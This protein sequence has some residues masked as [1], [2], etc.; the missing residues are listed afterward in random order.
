MIMEPVVKTVMQICARTVPNPVKIAVLHVVQ[1]ALHHLGPAT[2]KIAQSVEKVNVN[3][4]EKLR[5]KNKDEDQVTNN[6]LVHAC[7]M[8]TPPPPTTVL[9]VCISSLQPA[10]NVLKEIESPFITPLSSSMD[11]SLY[12]SPIL[13]SGEAVPTDSSIIGIQHLPR[14]ILFEILYRSSFLPLPFAIKAFR[15]KDGQGNVYI[16]KWNQLRP[17][18]KEKP[19]DAWVGCMLNPNVNASD[20]LGVMDDE[21]GDQNEPDTGT[22]VSD[23]SSDDEA[24]DGNEDMVHDGLAPDDH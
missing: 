1:I 21:A 20:M 23:I 5:R 8:T 11:S 6:R 22:V 15:N 16:I 9:S 2:K 14:E 13:A 12:A 3:T 17:S 7:P 4:V 19:C 18:V 10:T 24:D